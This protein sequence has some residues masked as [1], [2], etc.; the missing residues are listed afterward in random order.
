MAQGNL[1]Y[2]TEVPPR[3]N[4]FRHFVRV[5]FGRKVVIFGFFIIL[6][7]IIAAIF[8]PFLTPYD[9]YQINLSQAFLPPSMKH[10]LGT[11]ASGRDLLCR[12]IYGTRVSLMIGIVAVGS[13]SAIGITLGL[14]AGY[15][16]G[17]QQTIIMRFMDA[18][19]SLPP[20][21]TAIIIAAL[22]GTGLTNVMI[23]IGFSM[24]PTQCRVMCGQVL[25]VK[26][27]EYVLA[28]RSIGANN[29]RIIFKHVLPNC[30]PPLLVLITMELGAAILAE[31]GL[32]FLG[33][34]V[35]PPIA[36]WG[37]MVS[38]GRQYLGTY[39]LIALV[40]GFA[41]M[42][43]VFAFNMVGDGLRDALDPRLRGV[44]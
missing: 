31:A 41:I 5:F 22:L 8:A 16:G 2:A 13:A 39:P 14:V 1:T 40:P 6:G 42:L 38:D 34:G 36:A 33:I 4:E 28:Q 30:I 29:L 25:S 24:L 23:A 19:M 44:I 32:S 10:L 18:V 43:V 17:T 3:L 35:K 11:D 37:S 27:R 15:F 20:L 7:L 9:P 21:L 12:I 26:E